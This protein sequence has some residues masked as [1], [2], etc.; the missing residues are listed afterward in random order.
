MCWADWWGVPRLPAQG[1][2]ERFEFRQLHMGVQARLVLWAPG[3][4]AASEAAS[5]AF[6]RLAQLEQAMSDYRAGSELVQLGDHPAG[7]PVPVSADLFAVLLRSQQLARE[8]AGAFD[9]TVGPVVALWRQARRTGRLPTDSAIL[10]ARER[11]GWQELRLDATARTATLGRLGMGLDLGGIA[12][13][14]ACDQA[15]L[16][17]RQHGVKRALVE[18]GGDVAVSD[19]PPGSDGWPIEVATSDG[20]GTVLR[21]ARVAISTSGDSEQFVEIGGKR[22]SHVVDPRTGQ[23]LTSGIAVTVIAPDGMTSDG[24]ATLVSVLGRVEGEAFLRR[25]YPEVRAWIR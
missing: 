8:S 22:Y 18:L 10:T 12:K 24:L 3:R 25:Y 7:E 17:L 21:L 23:A 14:Y 20:A 5:A 16:A 19:P 13:G 9:V 6:E 11:V 2:L 15:L 4:A 1:V